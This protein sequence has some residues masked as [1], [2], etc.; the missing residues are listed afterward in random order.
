MDHRKRATAKMTVFVPW[1]ADRRGRATLA[2]CPLTYTHTC[3][4][5]C[6]CTHTHPG[7]NFK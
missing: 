4:H 1:D 3:T 7:C 6:T 2:S 5:A